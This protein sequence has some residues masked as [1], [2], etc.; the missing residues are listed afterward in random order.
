M[1][2]WLYIWFLGAGFLAVCIIIVAYFLILRIGHWM[3]K[4]Q[5]GAK[6]GFLELPP[7][8]KSRPASTAALDST[9]S[10]LFQHEK[11]NENEGHERGPG[12][13]SH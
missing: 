6:H 10:R 5:T 2:G 3:E 8:L 9:D 7:E 1:A 12:E 13:T 11:Q 4:N